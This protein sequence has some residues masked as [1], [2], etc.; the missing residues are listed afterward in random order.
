MRVAVAG[1]AAAAALG[2]ALAV[3]PLTLSTPSSMPRETCSAGQQ[4][5]RLASVLMPETATVSDVSGPVAEARPVPAPFEPIEEAVAP[6]LA[7][8][9]VRAVPGILT[10]R[11]PGVPGTAGVPAAPL[12]PPLPN[13]A[14]PGAASA[15]GL[16]IPGLPDPTPLL[17]I[18]DATS[19]AY[20]TVNWLLG[21]GS[22]A[23]GI[24]SSSALAVSSVL[25]AV[26]ALQ[27]RGLLPTQ[28]IGGLSSMLLPPALPGGGLPALGLP[29]L[30]GVSP[31][32]L[33]TL[34]AAG[35]VPG[36]AS[37]PGISTADIASMAAAVGLPTSLPALQAML[38]A[39]LTALAA[40]GLPLLLAAG[41]PA[42]L[43][44]VDPTVLAAALPALAAGLPAAAAGLPALPAA[45]ALPA[46]LPPLPPAPV[47]PAPPP[48]PAPTHACTPGFGPIGVC[49]PW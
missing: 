1:V 4:C 43:P 8:R 30:P 31:E 44:G 6:A 36:L 18:P 3:T 33:L 11:I 28:A 20:G 2:G 46:G 13:A 41:L 23:V 47:L 9:A 39:D 26:D 35:A 21:A 32:Q 24:V 7:P 29:G 25:L 45:A 19:A 42:G 12:V 37:L 40:G 15:P 49:T 16:A 17:G 38:P 27:A 22:T 34:A 14:V 48:L 10:P 5:D